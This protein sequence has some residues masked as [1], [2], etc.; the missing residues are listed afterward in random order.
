MPTSYTHRH[1]HA[2]RTHSTT[3]MTSACLG[4][5]HSGNSNCII[6]RIAVRE[7]LLITQCFQAALLHINRSSEAFTLLL[8]FKQEGTAHQY[9][10]KSV[11]SKYE[12]GLNV[13]SSLSIRR[14]SPPPT[15]SWLTLVPAVCDLFSVW[16]ILKKLTQ[17]TKRT[18][19]KYNNS[20]GVMI[21]V[22]FSVTTIL[23]MCFQMALK[24]QQIPK[25]EQMW[26]QV[27]RFALIRVTQIGVSLDML[28][29]Y[30]HW[31]KP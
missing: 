24:M 27:W 18:T 30:C 19:A 22:F 29:G 14:I 10:H 28:S 23:L 16:C 2:L 4:Y 26:P 21:F 7:T 17:E 6:E 15:E 9:R 5:N 20:E 8:G 13:F 11:H 12:W 3:G 1:T 25:K 31:N